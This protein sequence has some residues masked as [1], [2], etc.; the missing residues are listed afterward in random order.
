MLN[1]IKTYLRTVDH[2]NNRKKE[3]WPEQAATEEGKHGH[4]NVV[5]WPW[6]ITTTDIVRIKLCLNDLPSKIQ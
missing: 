4:Y 5:V 6:H 1:L 3:G 2:S